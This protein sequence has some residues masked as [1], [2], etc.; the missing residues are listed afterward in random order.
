MILFWVKTTFLKT[1]H[2]FLELNNKKWEQLHMII[3]NG[4]KKPVYFK[5]IFISIVSAILLKLY[6]WLFWFKMFFFH[7]NHIFLEIIDKKWKQLPII[8]ING[9]DINRNY[10]INIDIF[11]SNTNMLKVI[12]GWKIHFLKKNHQILEMLIIIK[13]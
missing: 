6:A 1:N 2:R 7:E 12:F 3:I 8:M 5:Y 9:K 10:T 11:F 4:K 13:K